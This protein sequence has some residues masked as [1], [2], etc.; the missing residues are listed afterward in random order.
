M[1]RIHS[2][3]FAFIFTVCIFLVS[4]L[5][6]ANEKYSEYEDL[7]KGLIFNSKLENYIVLPEL[8]A[9][10]A[11]TTNFISKEN[12]DT[13]EI[14][15][16]GKYFIQKFN[17]EQ[18]ARRVLNST[19]SSLPVVIN[20]RTGKLGIISKTI[21]VHLKNDIDVDLFLETYDYEIERRYDHLKKV[22]F[23]ISNVDNLFQEL[24]KLRNDSRIIRADLEI[25][26]NLKTTR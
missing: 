20:S 11:Q 23:Y 6:F 7:K 25:Y 14:K 5:S 26:E 13:T 3:Q 2:I 4:N 9:S 10:P 24:Q 16:I 12:K 22:Y 21:L 19:E 17:Q 18:N 1:N 8:I 15:K